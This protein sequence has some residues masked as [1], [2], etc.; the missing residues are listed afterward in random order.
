MNT[1]QPAG[2]AIRG[3]VAAAAYAGVGQKRLAQAVKD[4]EVCVLDLGIRTHY[5]TKS[6]LDRWVHSLGSKRAERAS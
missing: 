5:F 4:G 3:V 2:I 1:Q 6:E